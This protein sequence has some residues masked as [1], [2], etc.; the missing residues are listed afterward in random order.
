MREVFYVSFILA[1]GSP[2]RR[3]LLESLGLSFEVIPPSSEENL[4]LWETPRQLAEGL[5]QQKARQVSIQAGTSVVLAADTIVVKDDC[6]MGKPH[7]RREACEMLSRLSGARHQVITG[8][9]L[10]DTAGRELVDS[11]LT[12]VHFRK[13]SGREIDR[14]VDSGEPFDKAGGYG[15]QGLGALLVSRVDGCFYNVVG[16]PLAKLQTMLQCLGISLL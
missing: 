15:I 16:L 8:L 7:D 1:S 9:C 14:Y 10:I 4:E 3:L 6:I 5:A 13:L 11:E 2:R 12:T